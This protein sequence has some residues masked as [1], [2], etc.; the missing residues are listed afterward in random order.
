M[1]GHL[2]GSRSSSP[3]SLPVLYAVRDILR[4]TRVF[5]ESAAGSPVSARAGSPANPSTDGQVLS[6]RRPP[7]AV[8]GV[9]ADAPLEDARAAW[10]AARAENDPSRLEGMS[11]DLRALAEVRCKELDAAWEAFQ[12]DRA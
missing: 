10:E 8:L 2:R 6:F 11:T 7:H 9:D 3:Y 4:A 5:S 1:V 12:A